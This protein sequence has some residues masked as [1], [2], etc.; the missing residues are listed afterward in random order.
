MTHYEKLETDIKGYD[1]ITKER[2]FYLYGEI[3]AYLWLELISTT[4][5]RKLIDMLPLTQEDYDKLNDFE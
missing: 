3:S 5:T 1:K 2:A 4:Q